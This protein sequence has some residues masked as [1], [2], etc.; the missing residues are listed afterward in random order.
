MGFQQGLSGLNA[1]SRALDVIGNN[2]ANSQ[3]VGYKTSS[4][5]FAD[6]FAASLNGA[7]STPVGIGAKVANVVQQFT[8]GNVSVTNNPL[9]TAINGGG[10][11]QMQ[12]TTGS[13]V[14]SRNG[15][16]QLNKEGYIVNGQGLQ[17]KG[18]MAVNGVV[19]QGSPPVP[20]RL[21]N[22]TESLSG[23][24][25]ATGE[26]DTATGVQAN[27]NL[28]SR[29]APPT[30]IPFK[31]VGDPTSYNQSTAVTI[32]DSLGNPHTFS[33]YFAKLSPAEGVAKAENASAGASRTAM[34]AAL[35]VEIADATEGAS[36]TAVVGSIET[37]VQTMLTEL[38]TQEANYDAAMALDPVDTAAAKTAIQA[39]T[40]AVVN[41]KTNAVSNAVTAANE[42]LNP[43]VTTHAETAL[44]AVLTLGANE[45]AN[46]W[47]TYATMTNPDGTIVDLSED[48]TKTIDGNPI[49][50][51]G[52]ELGTTRFNTSGVLTSAELTVN[53]TAAQLGY[54]AGV[55][56]LQFDVNFKGSTQYGAPF[57]VNALLQDGYS[58]GSLAGF[59]IGG[60]GIVLGRYTNGQTKA[61][62]QVILAAFRNPQGL[63]PL[64]DNVWAQAPNSGDPILGEPGS[65]GQYGVLQ[66]ASLEDSNVDLTGELVNMITLQRV[67][68]ANA[69]TI[70]TQDSILQT[71]VNLR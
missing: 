27:L 22:P 49:D 33:M 20:L 36:A 31:G 10:F 32:Y 34:E 28:D 60:D 38:Q 42:P 62:G 29:L 7:G 47:L 16:F 56:A 51:L 66:S 8:Q 21:F 53:L 11:F 41:F 48:G 13:T 43:N 14:Y 19:A 55:N 4:S 46:R 68:Q 59:N 44:A 35:S 65:S 15:Q 70:K 50:Y 71:L 64:G 24:P 45:V 6:V 12:D 69:Q 39:M 67:Y 25:Q 57:A 58:S 40:T 17:L 52:T 37:D 5:Q 26:S 18:I 54:P 63:Q 3:T 61:V 2:I 1:S 30:T 9:D 23:T